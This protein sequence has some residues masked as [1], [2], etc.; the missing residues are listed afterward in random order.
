MWGRGP[1]KHTPSITVKNK[2]GAGLLLGQ[3]LP[4][5]GQAGQLT[6][7]SSHT[8]TPKGR[9][10]AL[11]GPR[12]AQQCTSDSPRRAHSCAH[13][14]THT[15]K[16]FEPVNTTVIQRQ[17]GV[18]GV[19]QGQNTERI[20]GR[21]EWDGKSCKCPREGWGLGH[22][23]GPR[24]DPSYPALRINGQEMKYKHKNTKHTCT[25][26]KKHITENQ[27]CLHTHT[28][29]IPRTRAHTGMYL[30]LPITQG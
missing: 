15:P 5:S 9:A 28:H 11:A 30:R 12:G 7:S 21:K 20:N 29:T 3:R 1:C 10:P 26:K 17:W 14:H 25:L 27:V 6:T 24:P 22:G 23:M 4:G 8:A 13:T 18:K 16:H 2:A 19:A